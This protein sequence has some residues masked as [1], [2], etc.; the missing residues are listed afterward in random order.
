MN[1]HNITGVALHNSR[2]GSVRRL[3]MPPAARDAPPPAGAWHETPCARAAVA[4]LADAAASCA[5]AALG[6]GAG[7]LALKAAV[8]DKL[9]EWYEEEDGSS[10]GRRV[11]CRRTVHSSY[12]PSSAAA[13]SAVL[14]SVA[15]LPLFEEAPVGGGEGAL[16]AM[17]LLT[18]TFAFQGGGAPPLLRLT[19]LLCWQ[20]RADAAEGGDNDA[21]LLADVFGPGARVALPPPREARGARAFTHVALG[22]DV[23][24]SV[25]VSGDELAA[26]PAPRRT[27]PPCARRSARSCCPP[28]APAWRRAGRAASSSCTPRRRR[29]AGRSCARRW[30]S[31]RCNLLRQPQTGTNNRPSATVMA[32]PLL[33]LLPPKVAPR[34]RR[35]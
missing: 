18:H 32:P 6:G 27:A 2:D 24:S 26:M 13:S 14:P 23:A 22:D 4:A 5:R 25:A 29:T 20:R 7:A 33:L 3:A 1:P 9:L 11:I 10:G 8:V 17:T 15:R 16:P 31:L 34:R 19:T 30:T 28:R 12:P 21:T 35:A